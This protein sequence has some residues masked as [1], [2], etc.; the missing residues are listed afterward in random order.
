MLTFVSLHVMC[1]FLCPRLRFFFMTDFEQFDYDV[2]W[3][4]LFYISY[5]WGSLSYL[6]QCV[7]NYHY[8][9]ESFGYYFFKYSISSSIL[10]SKSSNYIYIYFN[11]LKVVWQLTKSLFIILFCFVLLNSLFSLGFI[12]ESLYCHTFKFTHI[13]Y[14]NV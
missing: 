3:C 10:F 13:F 1:F 4:R 12:L 11:S 9:W 7:Y 8:V 5:V 2:H 14:Y 6:E